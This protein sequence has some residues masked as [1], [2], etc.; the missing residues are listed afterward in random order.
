MSIGIYKITNLINGKSYIGQSIHIEQRW[1]EHCRNSSKRIIS[2]AIQ[3]YGKD[4]FKFEILEECSQDELDKKER[5]YIQ[6]FN[7]LVPHGYNVKLESEEQ[8]QIFKKY[9][10]ETLE[11]ILDD[12]EKTLMPFTEIANKYGLDLSMIYY[13]NRGVYHTDS[14]RHY[15]LRVVKNMQKQHNYCIDC[16][17]EISLQAN[18]C[19]QCSHKKQ[20][21]CERPSREVLKDMIRTIPFEKIGQMFHVSGKAIV[22]WCIAYQLPSKK[23][24]IKKFSNE[25]WLKI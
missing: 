4:N 17:I 7:S 16:G 21:V 3:K 22:K 12:I 5:F 10:K 9:S 18:R 23:K 15:P 8:N 24:D 19:I 6:K 20:Q 11:D 1:S 13:L 14:D 25:E 2:L